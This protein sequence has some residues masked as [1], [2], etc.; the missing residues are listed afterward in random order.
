ME[1]YDSA[2]SFALSQ[3]RP[4]SGERP[5]LVCKIIPV[6]FITGIIFLRRM[7]MHNL[8]TAAAHSAAVGIFS[9]FRAFALTVFI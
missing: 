1:E 4:G 9:P 6:A 3:I 7:G 8:Q 2:V 5:K